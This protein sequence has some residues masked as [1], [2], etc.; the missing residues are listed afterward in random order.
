MLS[1]CW[2]TR[3]AHVPLLRLMPGIATDRARRV[4]PDQ[5]LEGLRPRRFA[6]MFTSSANERACIFRITLPR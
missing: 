4:Y 6:A 2:N 5:P 3:H 1:F